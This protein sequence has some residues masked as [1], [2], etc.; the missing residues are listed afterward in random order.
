MKQKIFYSVL[1][2]F[3]LLIAIPGVFVRPVKAQAG[4]AYDLIAAVN[5][6]R[7][8]LGLP[9]LQTD[10]IL[11]SI[12]Q[13]HS[14][15]QASIGYWTH[16]GPGGTRPR[17]RA[18]AAGFG[19]GASVFLSENVAV[20]NTSASFET[21]I[22]STWSDAIHWN[23]MTNP[24]Y[25]HA[26]AG[27]AVSGDEVYYTLD[28]GYIAGNPGGTYVP[29]ATYTPGGPTAAATDSSS[30]LIVPMMTSTPHEDGTVIHVVQPGQAFWSI[31][32]AYGTTINAIIEL[33]NLDPSNPVVWAGDELLIQPS[34]EATI[35]P[36][37]TITVKAPTRTP[38][39]TQTP[40]PPTAT[41]IAT[42]VFTPTSKPLIPN[43]PDIQI[44]RPTMGIAIIVTCGLGLLMVIITG[45]RG[46]K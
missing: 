20:L 31:A 11:M 9:A 15:Y 43:M 12:A 40:R 44:E 14:D 22:Y 7:A 46:K 26:G 42:L 36:T 8:S 25:T 21:L 37:S 23:T 2:L 6:M 1:I 39:P 19:G 28:V 29:A 10:G 41:K 33:N 4:N 5:Q 3:F 16:E 30:E 24:N 17:D 13:S 45:F 34:S 27:V 18:I 35:P 32:I 38:N